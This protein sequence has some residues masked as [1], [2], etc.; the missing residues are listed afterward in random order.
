MVSHASLARLSRRRR[1]IAIATD[2]TGKS[3]TIGESAQFA[4]DAAL[5]TI[6]LDGAALRI[7]VGRTSGLDLARR[8]TRRHQAS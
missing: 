7:V 2:E 5:S 4:R 8:I 6:G 3:A 1:L